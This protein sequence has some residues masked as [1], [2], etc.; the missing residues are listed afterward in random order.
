MA[1]KIGDGKMNSAMKVRSRELLSGRNM[2]TASILVAY[3]AV[4]VGCAAAPYLI[5]RGIGDIPQQNL[6]KLALYTAF[7]LAAVLIMYPLK[8]GSEAWFYFGAAGKIPEAMHI[9]YWFKPE[10]AA[11][12]IVLRLSLMLRKGAW[13]VVFLLP[14]AAVTG[15]A[16]YMLSLGNASAML[17]AAAALGGAVMLIVGTIFFAV[18]NQRYFLSTALLARYP[19]KTA[20]E[21]IKQS[22]ETMNGSLARVFI[23]KISFFPWFMLC[24]AVIPIVYVWPYYRQ[25]CS[26]MRYDLMREHLVNACDSYA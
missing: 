25:A 14:G 2:R 22:V 15:G 8:T 18:M 24:L 13:A 6:I 11:R 17:L 20:N 4:S 21:A 9:L 12:S 10:K 1:Q 19:Y 23:Y 3:A 5:C 16:L 26:C 7:M